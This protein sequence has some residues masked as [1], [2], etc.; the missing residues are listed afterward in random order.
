M[1]LSLRGQS[2]GAIDINAPNAA[3]NNTITLPGSN[4]AANQFYK[5]SAT[6]GTLTHSSM[7]ELSNG[8]IGIGSDDPGSPLEVNGGSSLDVATFNSHNADGPLINVQRSGTAIGFVGSG[9]N[10]HST[11][12]SVDALALRSQAE[13]TIATGGPTERL[14]ITSAGKVRV[15]SG[16]GAYN[17][18]VYGS[19]AQELLIGSTN[20]SLAGILLDG[21]SNG[22]GAGGDYAQIF[23]NTDGTLNFRARNGS[24]GTDT[25][26]LSGT[27]EKLRILSSGGITFN[28]DTAT[29]NAL[30]DYEEG[31]WTPTVGSGGNPSSTLVVYRARYTKIG[32]QVTLGCEIK[33]T[34]GDGGY[35]RLQ[36]LPFNAPTT[37]TG[38]GQSGAGMNAAGAL[39]F[40]NL[41]ITGLNCL[42]PYLWSN[43]IYFYYTA[44]TDGASWA[45]ILGSQ[46]GGNSSGGNLL[47]TITYST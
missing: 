14:R 10:L 28:G 26:F 5:N 3:G 23:H 21:D 41:N 9:K 38:P 30:D 44:A 43:I 8:R 47:F 27:S 40:N 11:T 15:G 37:G 7:I 42:T 2:S 36:G 17:L 22:D 20:A 45:E 1:G 24:G 18:E 35:F 12:G 16:N 19:G 46:V 31:Y 13:F 32:R 29:E 34:G 33:F 4:G 39:T 25:I 6:A